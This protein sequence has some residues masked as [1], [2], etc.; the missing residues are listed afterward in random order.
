MS[1]LSPDVT[2]QLALYEVYLVLQ[3]LASH[4]RQNSPLN[5][6]QICWNKNIPCISNCRFRSDGIVFFAGHLSPFIAKLPEGLPPDSRL[7]VV[8]LCFVDSI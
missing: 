8:H 1:Q 7:L 2:V 4:V 6:S 5:K 3:I